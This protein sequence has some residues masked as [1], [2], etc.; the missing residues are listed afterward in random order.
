M[1]TKDTL[2]VACL[3]IAL[4]WL[5]LCVDASAE[6]ATKKIDFD[7]KGAIKV[8]LTL[9]G[10]EV[11]DL[12]IHS[13]GGKSKLSSMNKFK[14]IKD[15]EAEVRLSNVTDRVVGDIGVA[16]AIMDDKGRLLGVASGEKG[17]LDPGEQG[18]VIV[19]FK[20]VNS[21]FEEATS[22]Y[23]TLDIKD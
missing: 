8:E 6:V 22:I 1:R 17:S 13:T 18:E 14:K 4:S 5:Y 3:L 2:C 10:V 11:T 16:L 19:K 7:T 12:Y 23:I 9:N 15:P 20:D 21:L